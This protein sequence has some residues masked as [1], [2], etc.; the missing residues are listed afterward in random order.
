MMRRILIKNKKLTKGKGFKKKMEDKNLVCR[1]CGNEFVFSA[2]EQEFYAGKNFPDP[3]RC[4]DCRKVKK[5]SKNNGK[6]SKKES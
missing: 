6:N 1:D 4:P 2:G 5:E 3:V